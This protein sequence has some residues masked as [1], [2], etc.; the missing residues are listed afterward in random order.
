MNIN[1]INYVLFFCLSPAQG[2]PSTLFSYVA[3]ICMCTTWRHHCMQEG[4][5]SHGPHPVAWGPATPLLGLCA[6]STCRL[7]SHVRGNLLF[8]QAHPVTWGAAPTASGIVH[9]PCVLQPPAS[10]FWGHMQPVSPS[11]ERGGRREGPPFLQVPSSCAP[12]RLWDCAWT[13]LCVTDELGSLYT[14]RNNQ[15]NPELVLSAGRCEVSLSPFHR[16]LCVT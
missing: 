2:D 7:P 3:P 13:P 9:T 1:Y 8:L 5:H 6:A 15:N 14:E 10:C 4:E 12:H 16:P 11:C